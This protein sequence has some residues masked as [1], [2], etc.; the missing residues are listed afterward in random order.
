MMS[1]EM[2]DRI[3]ILESHVA[4]QRKNIDDLNWNIVELKK[5]HEKKKE[6]GATLNNDQCKT[7]T[8][9]I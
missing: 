3:N 4:I 6:P 2:E 1:N 7:L 9:S 5:G 8:G